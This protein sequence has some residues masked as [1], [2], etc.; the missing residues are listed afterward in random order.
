MRRI[1]HVLNKVTQHYLNDN[2][3]QKRLFELAHLLI[4]TGMG[5]RLEMADD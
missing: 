4:K 1:N 3:H 5:M 2:S